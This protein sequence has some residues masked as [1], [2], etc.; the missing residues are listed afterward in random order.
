MKACPWK[1]PNIASICTAIGQEP[2]VFSPSEC[3]IPPLGAGWLSCWEPR[4]EANDERVC[5]T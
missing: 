5:L 2:E 3:D 4:D 1:Y